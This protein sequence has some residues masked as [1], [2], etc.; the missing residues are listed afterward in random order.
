MASYK[1]DGARFVNND[2]V[3]NLFKISM[4]LEEILRTWIYFFQGGSRILIRI[5]IKWILSTDQNRLN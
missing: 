1:G 2:G 3:L 5:K 4:N